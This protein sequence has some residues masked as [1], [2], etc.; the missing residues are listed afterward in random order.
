MV[1]EIDGYEKTDEQ[2]VEHF[3]E[4]LK[5]RGRAIAKLVIPNL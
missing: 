1:E 4:T 3:K 2:E 5:A